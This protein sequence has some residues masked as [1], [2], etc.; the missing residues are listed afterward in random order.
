M[1]RMLASIFLPCLVI[2]LLSSCKKKI[3]DN[4]ESNEVSKEVLAKIKKLGF[5]TNYVVKHDSGYIVE[6]DIYLGP[7]DLN[8]I[9]AGQS[10]R[11]ANTEHYRTTELVN[12]PIIFVTTNI[13]NPIVYRLAVQRAVQR[14]EALNLDID[15]IFTTGN[16]TGT[17]IN[18]S[19]DNSIPAPASSGFPIGGGLPFLRIKLNRSIIG[20]NPDIEHLASIVAHE[21][22]HCIGFRHTDYMN[23]NFSCIFDP[24]P[25]EGDAGIG[26]IHIPG[27]PTGPD[28]DS[29]MLACIS[30]GQNRPFTAN[31]IIALQTIY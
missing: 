10:I 25:D 26:A 19:I 1:K 22:G 4:I 17:S 23:R 16:P 7:K 27:T 31:D 15:F 12:V 28:A 11:I 8:R 20:D 5:S 21:L 2:F 14:Y 9:P 24:T 13:S 18:V 3:N 6:G 30:P 29:W